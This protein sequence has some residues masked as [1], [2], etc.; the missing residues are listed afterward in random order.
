MIGGGD[1]DLRG[2]QRLIRAGLNNLQASSLRQSLCKC[3]RKPNRHVLYDQ[4]RNFE[5][6]WERRQY[7]GKGGWSTG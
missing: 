7:A 6:E 1:P 5:I 3:G 4:H 2:V